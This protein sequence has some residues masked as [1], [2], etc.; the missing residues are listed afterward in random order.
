MIPRA[1]DEARACDEEALAQ[2]GHRRLLAGRLGLAVQGAVD[3][4]PVRRRQERRRLVRPR[5]GVGGVGAHRG[6]VGP[7]PGPAAQRVE[8]PTDE[9]RLPRHLDDRVPYAVEQGLVRRRVA[10]IGGHQPCPVGDFAAFAAG[11]ARHVMAAPDRLP[12]Q[13]PADPCSTAQ[14]QHLHADTQAS[15]TSNIQADS[16]TADRHPCRVRVCG[17][18]S[19]WPERVSSP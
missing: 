17:G 3:L 11:E 18:G 5:L 19:H 15:V 4:A 2:G 8:R 9:A 7:V 6:H 14:N 13:L 1:A 10:A 16:L 12:R